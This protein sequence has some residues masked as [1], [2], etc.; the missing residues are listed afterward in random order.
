MKAILLAA[1][2]GLIL[3][4]AA[5]VLLRSR[6][7]VHRARALVLIFLA[8]LVLLVLAHVATPDD[9]GLLPAS[10]LAPRSADLVFAMFLLT[11]GFFGGVLQVY[12]LADRGLSLRLLVDIQQSP[13]GAA[14]AAELVT[15][16]AGGRGLAWMYDKRLEGLRDAGL[17]EDADDLIALTPRGRRVAGLFAVLHRY[18]RC[19]AEARR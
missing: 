3:V 12:N 9:L 15:R 17:I 16:Y 6:P 8:C 4:L 2:C 1:A 13:G 18:C 14:T 11:A 19:D 5:T 7:I 10:L